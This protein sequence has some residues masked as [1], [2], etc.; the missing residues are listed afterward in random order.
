VNS[1]SVDVLASMDGPAEAAKTLAAPLMKPR[2][3]EQAE[4]N[5]L[6]LG[7]KWIEEEQAFNFAVIPNM[8]R[9]SLNCS[10]P[11]PIW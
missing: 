6:P 10:T 1:S 9:V 4:G 3:W 2:T 11:T 7:I 5:P 8:R